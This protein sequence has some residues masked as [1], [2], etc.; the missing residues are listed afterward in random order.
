[1]LSLKLDEGL[2]FH[3]RAQRHFACVQNQRWLK[4]QPLSLFLAA[5]R[6]R[7]LTILFILQIVLLAGQNASGRQNV[8]VN[9]LTVLVID[10]DVRLAPLSI[11]RVGNLTF[12][13]IPKNSILLVL[14][15][16]VED[17][18]RQGRHIYDVV[19]AISYALQLL[20]HHVI[21]TI[22]QF[23]LAFL[24]ILQVPTSAPIGSI[25]RLKLGSLHFLHLLLA[26]HDQFRR[27]RRLHDA[28]H[29]IFLLLQ[30]VILAAFSLLSALE[31][32]LIN[33]LLQKRRLDRAD[34]LY[35]LA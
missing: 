10:H 21:Q 13:I 19:G 14:H 3:R 20:G 15:L 30:A 2:R 34:K 27:P 1:M 6:P 28:Y 8:L 26:H 18:L 22:L 17:V 24:R 35:W 31:R 25:L 11:Q 16:V 4:G 32:A 23:H 7:L 9:S 12:G 29:G 5:G 33:F